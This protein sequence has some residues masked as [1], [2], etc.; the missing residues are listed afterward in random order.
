MYSVP[1]SVCVSW[2]NKVYHVDNQLT[3]YG[4]YNIKHIITPPL[5]KCK[6]SSSFAE[7]SSR[8]RHTSNRLLD[9]RCRYLSL[10]LGNMR[11]SKCNAKPCTMYFMENPPIYMPHIIPRAV[12]GLRGPSHPHLYASSSHD[13]GQGTRYCIMA[14][15]SSFFSPS[16]RQREESTSP[17]L[18]AR[19]GGTT[20][21][22]SSTQ[23]PLAKRRCM[24]EST[25]ATCGKRGL[26]LSSRRRSRWLAAHCCCMVAAL[27]VVQQ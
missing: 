10:K 15:S 5:R 8:R 27:C 4:V 21:A 6:I 9:I 19:S 24:R 2:L 18:S 1:C 13:A 11:S 7:Q 14:E 17:A 22:A 3:V 26:A 25:G 20:S 16:S 12:G 23:R